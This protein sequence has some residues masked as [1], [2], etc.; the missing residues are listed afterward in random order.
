MSILHR[1]RKVRELAG[2]SLAKRRSRPAEYARASRG[3]PRP[4]DCKACTWRDPSSAPAPAP[5]PVATKAA[6]RK[7]RRG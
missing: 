5:A 6:P 4:T 2:E 1:R 3:K 7:K